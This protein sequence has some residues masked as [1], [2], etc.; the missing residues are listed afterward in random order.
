MLR[1]F[2]SKSK[3]HLITDFMRKLAKFMRHALKKFY[4]N[5]QINLSSNS[6]NNSTQNHK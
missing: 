4:E 3:N 6:S 5:L 1:Y 2:S